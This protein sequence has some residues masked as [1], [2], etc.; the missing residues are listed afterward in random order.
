M[1]AQ[2]VARA[3]RNFPKAVRRSAL[4]RAGGRC[5]TCGAALLPGHFHFD[6]AVAHALGGASDLANCQVLCRTC[7]RLKT[8]SRDIP[9]IAK[10]VRIADKAA[11]MRASSRPLPAGRSSTIRKTLSGTVV[12]RVSQSE[13][14]R[15]LMA[16]RYPKNTQ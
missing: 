2:I 13:A 14:H 4:A 12:P 7:H 15:A 3:V 10:L 11:G 6:H 8:A 1:A 16:Q 9:A 5:E